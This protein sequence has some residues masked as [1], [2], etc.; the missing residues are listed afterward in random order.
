MLY[1]C[2]LR[3]EKRSNCY[4][5]GRSYST[6]THSC[7]NTRS[8]NHCTI[9]LNYHNTYPLSWPFL[10]TAILH[11]L[12]STTIAHFPS[13]IN[14]PRRHRHHTTKHTNT[15]DASSRPCSLRSSTIISPVPRLHQRPKRGRRNTY[16]DKSRPSDNVLVREILARSRQEDVG[17]SRNVLR[18]HNLVV[19]G[20]VAADSD[21]DLQ[22]I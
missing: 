12:M 19:G 20:A 6:P 14:Q 17:L 22:I 10:L 8:G 18:D 4:S 3:Q 13:L 15:S 5:D 11:S 1:D 21:G 7:R 9:N 2:E 16:L